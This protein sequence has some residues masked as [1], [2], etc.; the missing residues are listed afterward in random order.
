MESAVTSPAAEAF[1]KNLWGPWRQ[2]PQGSG[3]WKYP[4]GDSADTE[5]NNQ[6]WAQQGKHMAELLMI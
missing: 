2:I 3:R 4:V 5:S 1:F 6:I